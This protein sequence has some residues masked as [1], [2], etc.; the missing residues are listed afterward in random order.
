MPMIC[1]GC[2]RDIWSATVIDEG[3]PKRYACERCWAEVF[4]P[5]DDQ[6]R[7]E[8]Q[9]ARGLRP[10]DPPPAYEPPHP[11]RVQPLYEPGQ[12]KEESE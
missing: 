12:W 4:R 6:A 8:A 2:G 10:N 5:A 3:P 9:R 11:E 1:A 7:H